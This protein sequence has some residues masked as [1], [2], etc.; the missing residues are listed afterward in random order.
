MVINR[1]YICT[2]SGMECPYQVPLTFAMLLAFSGFL[3]THSTMAIPDFLILAANIT[4]F[5]ISYA[6][7]A[8]TLVEWACV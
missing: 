3:R 5:L 7:D 2:V 6:C 4:K 1:C 8:I